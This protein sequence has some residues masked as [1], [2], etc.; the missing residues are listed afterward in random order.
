MSAIVVK[1]DG[2]V[3]CGSRADLRDFAT[4]IASGIS[5]VVDFTDAGRALYTSD[6][7]LIHI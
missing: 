5:G 2:R 1:Q 7:S 3:A 4:A 6:L